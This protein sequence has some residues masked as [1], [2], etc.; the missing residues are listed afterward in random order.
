MKF[1]LVVCILFSCAPNQAQKVKTSAHSPKKTETK[2]KKIIKKQKNIQMVKVNSSK[3]AR[4][5]NLSFQIKSVK[6]SRCP[7]GVQ[8]IIAGIAV[9]KLEVIQKGLNAKFYTIET[10]RGAKFVDIGKY[11]IKVLKLS[12]YPEKRK[13]IKL[14]D[15]RLNLEIQEK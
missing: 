3:S 13:R 5:N 7:K 15:Y 12:P 10:D 6:D 1:I 2:F 11:K 14:D 8:C 9:I 4:Y